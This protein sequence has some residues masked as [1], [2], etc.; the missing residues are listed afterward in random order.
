MCC[1]VFV[2]CKILQVFSFFEK[3][4]IPVFKEVSAESGNQKIM[5]KS[6]R[7]INQEK[8]GSFLKMLENQGIFLYA[9]IFASSSCQ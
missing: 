7:F 9:K 4:P 5:E 1:V 2:F 6:G 3:I 8:K